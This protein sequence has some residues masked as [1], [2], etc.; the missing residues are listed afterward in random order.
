MFENHILF[1]IF[2][3]IHLFLDAL[4]GVVAR[5]TK[6]TKK[7]KEFDN[8]VD[9]LIEFSALIK[10]AWSF[11]IIWLYMV[12]LIA[13]VSQGIHIYSRLQSPVFFSRTLVLL[14]LVIEL[15]L[16]AISLAGMINLWGLLL[17]LQWYWKRK[18]IS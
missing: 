16:V 3:L 18:Y 13:F 7:G 10:I 4:D 12:I 17:Q 5:I 6:P 15:P 2:A 11:N 1:V 8:L 9:R 14:F